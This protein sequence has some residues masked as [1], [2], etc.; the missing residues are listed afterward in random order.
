[1]KAAVS[2]RTP[3]ASPPN[4]YA[5][6]A[7]VPPSQGVY[8]CAKKMKRSSWFRMIFAWS[9]AILDGPGRRKRTTLN[10]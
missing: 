6:L 5:V 7:K 4:N 8:G 2:C 3:K 1:M 10:L 9:N